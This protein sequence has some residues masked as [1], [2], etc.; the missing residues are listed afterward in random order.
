MKH[1]LVTTLIAS[2]IIFAPISQARISM[3]SVNA[4]GEGATE[5][6]AI[7]AAQVQAVGQVSGE[8]I[9]ASSGM[10]KQ[11]VEVK[12]LSQNGKK[13]AAV[14]KRTMNQSIDSA[15]Q[16]IIKSTKVV[17]MSF[18]KSTGLYHA[19][20]VAEIPRLDQDP[21]LNRK[22]IVVVA[23]E[24]SYSNDAAS[25]DGLRTAIEGGLVNS[26]KVAILDRN[27]FASVEKEVNLALSGKAAIE[28]S[29][30]AWNLPI[31]DL[32]LLIDVQKISEFKDQVGNQISQIDAKIT[33]I[34]IA[35][36]QVKYQKVT[37]SLY[38]GT[39]TSVAASL[40]NIA[41]VKIANEILD[42]AFPA[43]VLSNTGNTLTVSAGNAQLKVGQS[44]KILKLGKVLKDPYTNEKIGEEEIEVARGK[45][46]YVMPASATVEADNFVMQTKAQYLVRTSKAPLESSSNKETANKPSNDDNW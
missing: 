37:K 28:E 26:R 3:I 44:V 18:D 41:G 21:Q 40:S 27:E 9:S 4:T 43:M 46:T 38:P 30:K 15:T 33:V 39:L 6:D 32:M 13:A 23:T 14:Q 11:S 8:V 20:I 2:L 1:L 5:S 12:E 35:S 16:G 29:V 31:A 34:D 10:K 36:R 22:R 24:R 19:E 45:V 42:Y 17:S 25:V 7:K